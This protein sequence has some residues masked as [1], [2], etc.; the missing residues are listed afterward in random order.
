MLISRNGEKSN[1]LS[2]V[3]P[4]TDQPK[5]SEVSLKVSVLSVPFV[6]LAFQAPSYFKT[7]AEDVAVSTA[8]FKVKASR[9]EGDKPIQ[10]SI[11]GGNADNVFTID[12]NNGQVALAK[13]LDYETTKKHK[14]VIRATLPSSN[15]VQQRQLVDISK[16]SFSIAH[17]S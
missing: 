1:V 2:S 6:P 7:L 10:Y 4:G 15:S 13:K 14:L 3:I 16:V 11:V 17:F 8:V 5:E 9:S 12:S